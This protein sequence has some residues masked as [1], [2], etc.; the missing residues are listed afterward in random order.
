MQ[1]AV[2]FLSSLSK[3]FVNGL[4]LTTMPVLNVSFLTFAL[5]IVFI[6]VLI[7]TIAA[8]TGN[9]TKDDIK[10]GGRIDN[11]NNYIYRR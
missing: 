11:N 4:R 8:V 5:S 10:T 1:D 3:A 6:K 7:W 2:N 9:G